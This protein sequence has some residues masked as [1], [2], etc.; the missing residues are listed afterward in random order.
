M[1]VLKTPSSSPLYLYSATITVISFILWGSYSLLCS[2]HSPLLYILGCG[3]K[4]TFFSS[5]STFGCWTLLAATRLCP[6]NYFRNQQVLARIQI[7][8]RNHLF[9]PL[10]LFVLLLGLLYLRLASGLL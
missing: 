3:Y 8:V 5:Y 10:F 6:W 7:Y 9:S 2:V 4:D 1:K